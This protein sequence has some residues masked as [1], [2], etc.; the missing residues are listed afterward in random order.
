VQL[1]Q[2]QVSRLRDVDD[3]ATKVNWGC[4]TYG[5]ILPRA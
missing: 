3:E 2:K 1:E 5:T 4:I